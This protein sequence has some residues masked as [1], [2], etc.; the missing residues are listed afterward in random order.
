MHVAGRRRQHLG[1]IQRRFGLLVEMQ[2]D[3][4]G[5][6]GI[7][8]ALHKRRTLTGAGAVMQFEVGARLGQAFGHAQDRGDADAAG[9]QQAAPCFVG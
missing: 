6:R 3:P 8:E 4:F 5:K 9:K 2:E 7:L 1:G